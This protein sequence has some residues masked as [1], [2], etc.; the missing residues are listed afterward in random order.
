MDSQNVHMSD[1]SHAWAEGYM[2]TDT[3]FTD[4]LPLEEGQFGASAF[5]DFTNMDTYGDS[6]G[7]LTLRAPGRMDVDPSET[8]LQSQ[9]NSQNMMALSTE[10]SRRASSSGSSGLP[11]RKSTE[12]PLIHPITSLGLNTALQTQQ[13]QRAKSGLNH[14]QTNQVFEQTFA[15]PM[16]NLSLEQGLSRFEFN[17]AASSPIQTRDPTA[18]N[19]DSQVHMPA[20]VQ[21][22]R[23]DQDSPMETINPEMFSVG[24]ARDLSAGNTATRMFHRA[25]PNAMSA[26]P[27]S[28]SPD[29]LSANQF[30]NANVVQDSSAWQADFSSQITPQADLGFTAA[31]SMESASNGLRQQAESNHTLGR[32]PLH[33]APISTKSRVE[34][35]IN[36]V[37]TLEKPPP[38]IEHLHLPLH[39]IAKSKL[40][41]KDEYDKSKSLELYTML[42]CTS[43]MHNAGFKEKA[44]KQAAAQDNKEIQNRAEL[45]RESGD[46]EK[47]DPKLVPDEDKP[48]NGGEVRICS[49]CIQ[50]ERKRAGRKKTKREEEQQ[51]WERF[52]TERVVV[53][54]S[55]E[56]LPFK[57]CEPQH[58]PH[59][60]SGLGTEADYY[61]P[62][63]GAL[64]VTA[65]MRIACYCRHQ[66]EKEGFQV[67]FTLKDHHGNVVAQQISDSIL[68]TDDHKTHPSGFP[69]AATSDSFYAS[70]FASNGLPNSQSMVDISTHMPAFTAS[71]SAGSLQALAYGSG[72]NTHNTSQQLTGA[73]ITNQPSSATH[74]SS[75]TSRPGS[76]TPAQLGPNKKRKSSTNFHRKI[77]SGLTM[78]PRVDT[79]QPASSNLSSAISAVSQFSPT[80]ATFAG[81]M[82]PY[83]N[84]SNNGSTTN[85][86]SSGPP[87]PSET[88][89]YFGI[90][91]AQID[92][93]YTT[94]NQAMFSQPSSAVPSR[95]S[96][97]VMHQG[98]GNMAAYNRQH[99]IQTS[100]NNMTAGRYP[101]YNH[102]S[103]NSASGDFLLLNNNNNNKRSQTGVSFLHL[104]PD[105]GPTTGGNEIAILGEH[106]VPGTRVLFGDH[107]SP[108]VKFLSPTSLLVSVPPSPIPG[109]VDVTLS[110]PTPSS[111]SAS[112]GAS[113]AATTPKSA[114]RY[115]DPVAPAGLIPHQKHQLHLQNYIGQQQQQQQQQ[116]P[117]AARPTLPGRSASHSRLDSPAERDAANAP[118][119][120]A[121]SS[122]SSSS[123]S[124]AAA[125]S[126][127]MSPTDI[128][129][130]NYAAATAAALAV[131]SRMGLKA[132]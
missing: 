76:P 56:Y 64:Q 24:S 10:S 120:N 62:P 40:L 84:M 44:M 74:V 33:I 67:I 80:S 54:N 21:L 105:H 81:Q 94:S 108:S 93:S 51:H 77:P 102:S 113:S 35:Q 92:A 106:F 104:S 128:L 97:P 60:D 34:T 13:Q 39:T 99:P 58:N 2:F 18:M 66:S 69:G 68:I 71:K 98:R 119:G 12:S 75:A 101:T 41:A 111:S 42:V 78:T 107:A 110:P 82:N 79:N 30:L 115:A 36:V 31:S 121:S 4:A 87:T 90:G 122:S 126:S 88:N 3:Q 5:D 27:P 16:H 100:T 59:R 52:E 17:S 65:A 95:A 43:A 15:Q 129:S 118:T 103:S 130:R 86:F 14:F 1:G 23:F 116:Q 8:T 55:N 20:L 22:N 29:N 37:M 117:F 57:P 124:A 45:A 32:S 7:G 83:M 61:M 109:A 70:G 114:Y 125:A 72:F 112:A 63:E 46:E 9:R 53:F 123:S 38:G 96:S 89:A 85:F 28:D 6:P 73:A 26:T 11:K 48:A 132:C 50:R 127:S 25:S 91:Q 49:N 47:N 19:L 131:A